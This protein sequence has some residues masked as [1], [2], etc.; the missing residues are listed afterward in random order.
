MVLTHA[1][2]RLPFASP[3]R[4]PVRR[5]VLW[6]IF[7]LGFAAAPARAYVLEGI[8]WPS[9]QA[10]QLD[11]N[12]GSPSNP[13]ADGS[14]SWN[15]VAEAAIAIWNP[16]LGDGVQLQAVVS[17]NPAVEQDGENSVVFSDSAF[18]ESFGDDTLGYTEYLFNTR[19]G[20][21]S[22][23]DVLFNSAKPF[24]SYRGPLRTDRTGH[25]VYDLRR[26]MLHEFGHLLGLDHV[27]QNVQAIMTP[28]TSDID[29]IQADDIAGVESI[30]GNPNLPTPVITGGLSDGGITEQPF[31]YQIGATNQPTSYQASGLPGGL[32]VNVGTGLISG[33]VLDPGTYHVTIGATNSAGTSTAVLTL[34]FQVRPA[35]T[36]PANAT[37]YAGYAFYYQI[38]ASGGPTTFD[39]T[40]LP[41]GLT[42][43]A[44]TGLISGTPLTGGSYSIGLTATNAVA[45]GTS[46]LNLT[47]DYDATLTILHRFEGLGT[48][49]ARPTGLVAGAD[50]FFYGTTADGGANDAGT[51]FR[52]APDGTLTTV[53]SF[54]PDVVGYPTSL[55][56]AADGS[57]YGIGSEATPVQASTL[58][59]I[60]PGGAASTVHRFDDNADCTA[61]QGADGNYYG[62]ITY[63]VASAADPLGAVYKLGA[64][65]TMTILHSFNSTDGSFPLPL[66]QGRDG[67]FYGMTRDGGSENEGT[68]FKVTADGTFTSLHSFQGQEGN[69]PA[70]SLTQGPDGA[71]YGTTEGGGQSGRGTVFRIT[72]DGAFT[73]IHAF[74]DA[75]GTYPGATLTLG[76]D[77]NFYGS[78]GVAG[79][80]G[81]GVFAGTIFK[82]TPTGTLTTLHTFVPAEAVPTFLPLV[83]A[84]NGTF[85]SASS[86]PD[87]LSIGSGTVFRITPGAVPPASVVPVVVVPS[88][89]LEATTPQVNVGSGGEGIFTVTLSAVQD[90]DVTVSY[91]IKGS[92][93]NGTDYVLLSGTRKIKAG[94]LSKP[95]KVIPQGDLG[96]A[97]KKV[98]TLVLAPGEGYTVGTT[99]K[100]KVKIYPGQ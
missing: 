9:D 34:V 64:D 21:A 53:F 5:A 80:G 41:G 55:L 33:L 77:G 25:Y 31:E 93:A 52:V 54:D 8:H 26:V 30:Y 42:F 76:G 6:G 78:S 44:N 40:S 19:T 14:T 58:Y 73:T 2:A 36:S 13:L 99:G 51:F 91:T 20:L 67:A 57:F 56:R 72:A 75:E 29:T 100:V 90:H 35:I 92:A 10:I 1:S 79:V 84:A 47:V 43:D 81:A 61:L 45:S 17:S 60:A 82:V 66:R 32:G 69:D 23:A 96:G 85:L 24:D 18:G 88:V 87:G 38:Q 83:P 68:I 70:G 39:A 22:E 95:I 16:Y 63:N 28:V 7:L 11:L 74:T 3:A 27:A 49:G 59:K 71:F 50:G 86:V 37:A 97:S 62:T 98:V 94:K 48:D 4:L 89:T 46:G 15:Q 65:G 12:L